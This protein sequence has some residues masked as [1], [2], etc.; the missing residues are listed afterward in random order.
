MAESKGDTGARIAAGVAI[1]FALGLLVA[2]CSERRIVIE[3]TGDREIRITAPKVPE[4]RTDRERE[5]TRREPRRDSRREARAH[6][7]SRESTRRILRDTVREHRG[8]ERVH[9]GT[10]R[11]HT[12]TERV[13][14]GTVEEF[15]CR[16]AINRR[17]GEQMTLDGE[18]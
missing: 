5:I 15:R 16:Y 11:V 7:G 18:C 6:D 2:T 13:Y 3:R 17:T 14:R 8:T 10:E 4:T 9:R 12:G 1:V